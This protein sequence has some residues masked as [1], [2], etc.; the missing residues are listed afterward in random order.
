MSNAEFYFNNVNAPKP[1]KPNLIGAAVLIEYNNTFLLEQRSDCD[2]WDFIGGSLEIDE[3][4]DECI[5]RE[6]KEETGIVVTE[7]NW[8]L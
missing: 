6:I 8:I 1:N 3:S 7:K 5:I 2:S 4:I